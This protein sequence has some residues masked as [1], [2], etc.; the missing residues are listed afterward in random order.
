MPT[1]RE[2]FKPFELG[3][4]LD[5]DKEFEN[6]GRLRTI[7]IGNNT[8]SIICEDPYGFWRVKLTKGNLPEKLKGSYTSFDMALRDVNLWLKDKKEPLISSLPKDK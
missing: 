2:N 1:V 6:G 3:D 5:D 8:V 4:I 7:D